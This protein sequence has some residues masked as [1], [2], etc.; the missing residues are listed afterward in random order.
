MYP[1]RMIS[2]LRAEP[3]F[4]IEWCNCV[5]MPEIDAMWTPFAGAACFGVDVHAPARA[6]HTTPN[7]HHLE[8][9]LT[10]QDSSAQVT[11]VAPVARMGRRHERRGLP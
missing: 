5:S 1:D 3:G 10:A 8:A 6:R 9:P 4:A 2:A 7:A 11:T